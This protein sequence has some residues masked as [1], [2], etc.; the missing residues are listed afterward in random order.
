MAPLPAELLT[1]APCFTYVGLDLAGPYVVTSMVNKRTTMKCWALVI[2]DLVSK[3]VKILTMAGY[4][5]KD[6]LLSLSDFTSNYG[7]PRLIHSDKGSQLVA[8]SKELDLDWNQITEKS[9]IKETT[10]KFCPAG[11]QFRYGATEAVVKKMKY[12]IA[13]LLP[14]LPRKLNYAEFQNVLNR[15]A[16]TINSR[17][18]SAYRSGRH[19]DS[20]DY[21]VPLTPNQLLTGRPAST[22]PNLEYD[23]NNDTISCLDYIE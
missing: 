23:D 4:S 11:G 17:P 3:A 18:I 20:E 13:H 16:N 19:G 8:A 9:L 21:I 10:W 1:P 22:L 7:W 2:V 15:V 12:S 6:F 5:T 14:T